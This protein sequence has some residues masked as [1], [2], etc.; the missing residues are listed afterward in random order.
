MEELKFPLQ[1]QELPR[2][3][4]MMISCKKFSAEKCAALKMTELIKIACCHFIVVE[5]DVKRNPL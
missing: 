3:H 2:T 5:I 4:P 1:Q